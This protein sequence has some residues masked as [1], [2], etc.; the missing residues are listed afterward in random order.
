MDTQKLR[1]VACAEIDKNAEDLAALSNVLWTNPELALEEFIA[2]D[3]LTTFL[4]KQDFDKVEKNFVLPTGFRAVFGDKSKGP[5][6]AIMSEFDALPGIGHACGH[7][8]IA[9]VGVAAALGVK[10]ALKSVD[11][12]FGQVSLLGTPAEEEHGGK[13]DFI[14]AGVFKDVD[15]AM[16]AHPAQYEVLR[17]NYVAISEIII[18]FI[19]VEA[20]AAEFP[21][22][23]VNALDAAILCYN[24]VSCMRQQLDPGWMI[25]GIVTD[26]GARP[27][28]IPRRASLEYYIRTPKNRDLKKL[29]RKLRNCIQG[30]A[31]ATNC[32]VQVK[33]R[34]SFL[35]LLSNETMIKKYEEYTTQLGTEVDTDETHQALGGGSTDMG[36]VSYE[37]PSIHPDFAIG[38]DCNTHTKEFT[39]AAGSKEAQIYT[40]RGA[41]SLAMLCIDIMTDKDFLDKIKQEFE[42]ESQ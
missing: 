6:V 9:E 3:A 15:A 8:L 19:G 10:A 22:E 31:L 34:S 17:P 18:D 35:N 4:D 41:K 30:A 28:I 37:V 24:N 14:K 11:V 12:P 1:D 13:I 25:H 21:W 40:L 32:E 7:N 2:H 27:N 5:H 36:N 39:P 26:G 33:V 23:G 29:E 16:M 38:S 20:H 42:E